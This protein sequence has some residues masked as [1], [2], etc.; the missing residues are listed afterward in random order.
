M[1]RQRRMKHV[2]PKLVN[3]LGSE[4]TPGKLSLFDT[5]NIN[6]CFD[7]VRNRLVGIGIARRRSS[8]YDP[9]V[10]CGFILIESLSLMKL[11]LAPRQSKQIIRIGKQAYLLTGDSRDTRKHSTSD[12]YDDHIT[13]LGG[14]SLI[15]GS[16]PPAF[17]LSSRDNELSSAH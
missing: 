6:W 8:L 3:V 10:R 2:E 13:M 11:L 4:V 15:W 9:S 17:V 14:H 5:N 12:G 7:V 16:L 1:P